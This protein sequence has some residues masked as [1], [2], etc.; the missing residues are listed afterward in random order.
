M[1]RSMY[2]AS[3]LS[4][5]LKQTA[6]VVLLLFLSLRALPAAE[7]K[8]ET[9]AAWDRYIRWANEKV[10]RE[11]SSP[12]VFLIQ[13]SISA[14]ER[15]SLQASIASGEIAVKPM[16]GVIPSGIHFDVP[17]GEIHHWWGSM[18]LRNTSIARLLQLLQD[19]DH[20]YERFSDVERSRLISKDGNRYKIFLRLSRSKAFVTT[21]YDTEQ[22]CVYTLYGSTRASSQST[23]TKIAELENAGTDHERELPPGKDRGFLW[24]LVSWWRFEQRGTDVVVELESASLSRGIPAFIRFMPGISSYIKSTPR[25][26]LESVLISIRDF[27]DKPSSK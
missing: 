8:R 11:L 26:T 3:P 22:D 24:R 14:A 21:H 25:E 12:G 27:I 6:T 20:H 5:L 7:L 9:A 15:A 2:K 1:P 18:L 10:Q 13:N 19:Y 4:L 16:K 17:D 23:A